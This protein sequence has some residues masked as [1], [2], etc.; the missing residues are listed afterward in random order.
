M[1]YSASLCRHALSRVRW[2]G[3]KATI[4][5]RKISIVKRL[6]VG[7]YEPRKL[8]ATNFPSVPGLVSVAASS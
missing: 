2:Y 7:E 6:N 1:S 8:P 3:R 4:R 5:L